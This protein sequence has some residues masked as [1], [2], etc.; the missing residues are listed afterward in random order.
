MPQSFD[1]AAQALKIGFLGHGE[2]LAGLHLMLA[3]VQMR[4]A[5]VIIAPSPF[6]LI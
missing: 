2:S 5:G 3:L 4:L 6:A 1:V